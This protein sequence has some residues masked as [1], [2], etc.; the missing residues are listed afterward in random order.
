MAH[1]GARKHEKDILRN[2]RGVI[3]DSLQVVSDENYIEAGRR[4]RIGGVYSADAGFHRRLEAG[5]S[6]GLLAG[7]AKRKSDFEGASLAR[8]RCHLEF[9][10]MRAHH[11][12]RYRKSKTKAAF[13]ARAALINAIEAVEDALQVFRRNAWS[14]IGDGNGN[15]L[16]SGYIKPDGDLACG[17]RV[18]DCVVQDIDESLPDKDRIRVYC[19]AGLGVNKDSLAFFFRD[20]LEHGDGFPHQIPGVNI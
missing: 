14:R 19:A 11:P 20:R 18:F 3:G 12:L 8:R 10:F 13:F 5:S 1:A 9:A 17:R 7:V 4:G 16:K 6:R 15:G 2:I